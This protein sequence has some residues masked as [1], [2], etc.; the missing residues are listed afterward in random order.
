MKIAQPMDRD[1][2]RQIITSNEAFRLESTWTF[3][4]ATTGAVTAHTLFTVTD[5]VLL[6]VF[7]VVDT[8]LTSGGSATVEVGVTG[9]TAVLIGQST[10]TALA[11]GEIWR[12]N[13]LTRVGAGEITPMNIIN[14]GSDII[15][16]IGT[17]TVTAGAIDFYCL[18]RPLNENSNVIATTPA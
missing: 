7:G 15:L 10:A 12:D 2:N 1:A 9:N 13:T 14:D 6:C 11:D 8:T 3:A 5:N 18:W 4:A 16:T 17:A